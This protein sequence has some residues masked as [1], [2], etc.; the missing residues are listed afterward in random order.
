M[1][2]NNQIYRKREEN[3]ILFE[4][5]LGHDITI[6]EFLEF[7]DLSFAKELLERINER[8]LVSQFNNIQ[9][10]KN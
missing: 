10:S 1:K 4:I 3:R 2:E 9:S 7:S 8:L 6:Q 5:Y